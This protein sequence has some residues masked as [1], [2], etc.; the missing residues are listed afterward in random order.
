[1]S[2][3]GCSP[4]VCVRWCIGPIPGGSWR[5]YGVY[6]TGG[7]LDGPWSGAG[8]GASAVLVGRLQAALGRM[9]AGGQARYLGICRFGYFCSGCQTHCRTPSSAFMG[10]GGQTFGT[11]TG[12]RFQFFSLGTHCDINGGGFGSGLPFPSAGSGFSGWG[13]FCGSLTDF[14]GIAFPDGYPGWDGLGAVGGLGCNTIFGYG[15]HQQVLLV[16]PC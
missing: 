4:T 16:K 10:G 3:G 2:G 12:F 8:R 5:S 15:S 9:A 14:G 11:D 1:M 13:V 7:L 6:G